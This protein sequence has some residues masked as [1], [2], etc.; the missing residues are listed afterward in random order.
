MADLFYWLLERVGAGQAA[1][2][3]IL[4][5]A[6]I[7]FLVALK[8]SRVEVSQ[9]RMQIIADVAALMEKVQESR[10]RYVECTKRCRK[11]AEELQTKLLAEASKQE[12]DETRELFCSCLIEDTIP[13]FLD[14]F[15]F[16]RLD[17]A[18]NNGSPDSFD[19]LLEDAADELRRFSK[20]LTTINHPTLIEHLKRSKAEIQ[21][22]T[23]RPFLVAVERFP[24]SIRNERCRKA[25]AVAAELTGKPM[26]AP[27]AAKPKGGGSLDDSGS[28][29]ST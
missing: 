2:I 19:M 15:E 6:A 12:L 13:A 4:L 8:K 9:L 17:L 7:Y 26:P 29:G 1:T 5:F 21:T 11:L 14:G 23:L 28:S 20:W 16:D 3:G 18:A 22:R 24:E 27:V 10:K 25:Q